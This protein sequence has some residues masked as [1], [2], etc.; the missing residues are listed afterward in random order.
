MCV[1]TFTSSSVACFVEG[2]RLLSQTGYKS[3]ENLRNTDLLITSDGRAVSYDIYRTTIVKTDDNTAPYVIQPGAFGRNTPMAPLYLSPTHKVMIK[4]GVW[5][6]PKDVAKT[7]PLVKRCA[8]GESV[9][10][11]HIKCENYLRD[12]VIAEGVVT[13]TLGIDKALGN[14]KDVYKWSARL[15]GYTRKSP[16]SL[17]K[18]KML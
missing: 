11:Y 10:Y 17:F 4:N 16:H 18:N 8:T 1:I 13:E 14:V 9:T 2:T 5:V 15:N 12:N 7:N 3:V 6:S